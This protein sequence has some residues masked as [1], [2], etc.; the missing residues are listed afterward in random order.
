MSSLNDKNISKMKQTALLLFV[1]AINL[2]VSS[3]LALIQGRIILTVVGSEYNGLNSI[4]TQFLLIVTLAEGGFTTASLV[5]LF[6]PVEKNDIYEINN[7]LGETSDRFK[8]IGIISIA[9]GCMLAIVYSAL[10]KT[11]IPYLEVLGIIIVA[12]L[13]NVISL[14]CL[15]K[16]RLLFQVTQKEHVYVAILLV[17][18]TASSLTATFVIG[19]SGSV[20]FAKVAQL[21]YVVASVIV[22]RQVVAKKYEMIDYSYWDH[23]KRVI[24][25]KDVMITKIVGVIHSSSTT[26]FLSLFSNA[27]MTSVYGVYYSVVNLISS[28]INMGITAPQNALGKTINEGNARKTEKVFLEFELFVIIALTILLIP[29]WILI[30]PFVNIYTN[31]VTDVEYTNEALAAL[32]VVATYIRL[33]HIPSGLMI[34]LSGKFKV[35]KKI[36][37][38]GLI[39]LVLCNCVLGVLWGFYGVI[40]SGLLCDCLL[41]GLEIY[42][43]HEGYTNKKAFLSF[44]VINGLIFFILVT[45][46]DSISVMI[47][48]SLVMLFVCGIIVLISTAGIVVFTNYIL[49]KEYVRS[50]FFRVIHVVKKSKIG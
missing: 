9:S 32:L 17:F 50:V 29:T 1:S 12:V 49:F 23:K 48:D 28:V 3:V 20:F 22:I 19:G 16:Y 5:A 30:I 10:I 36:Q 41:A 45:V 21:M 4:V 18:N 31:G 7:I 27:K 47:G 44:F 2:L 11:Q 25:T 37:T 8:K 43:A 38:V 34:F 42:Y 26:I 46:L 14:M 13:S 39:V 15:T 40:I 24:G 33:V 6:K 35:A